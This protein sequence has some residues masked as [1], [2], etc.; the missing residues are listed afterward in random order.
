MN[1][2]VAMALISLFLASAVALAAPSWVK[3]GA[4]VSINAAAEQEGKTDVAGLRLVVKQ[5]QGDKILVDVTAQPEGETKSIVIDSDGTVEGTPLFFF[6]MPPALKQYAKQSGDFLIVVHK[7]DNAVIFLIYNKFEMFLAGAIISP[8]TKSLFVTSD[9]NLG[10]PMLDPQ[11]LA[12]QLSKQGGVKIPAPP[13]QPLAPCSVGGDR[14]SQPTPPPPPPSPTTTTNKVDTTTRTITTIITTT[15]VINGQTTTVTVTTTTP[16]T[17]A[18]NPQP[19]GGLFSGQNTYYIIGG[20]IGAVAVTAFAMS[21]RGRH[22]PPPPQYPAYPQYPATPPPP[23]PPPPQYPPPPA[24]PAQYPA[25]PQVP[26]WP[27]QLRCPNCG[28]QLRGSENVCP[29]CGYRLR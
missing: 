8:D 2:L 28:F 29:N 5:V 20:V 26:Q 4:C 10:F 16:V 7:T 19:D 25:S 6:F 18:P 15:T 24:Q 3:P 14:G 11:D 27:Q 9:N 1:K 17:P 23:Q 13:A 21:R 12:T 22:M